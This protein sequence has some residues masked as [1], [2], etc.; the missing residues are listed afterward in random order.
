VG[1]GL[2]DNTPVVTPNVVQL[3]AK[4]PKGV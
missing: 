2:S 1:L 4:A 3:T